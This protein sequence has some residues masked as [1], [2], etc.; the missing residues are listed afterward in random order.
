MEEITHR[1]GSRKHISDASKK[2]W[3][4][5]FRNRLRVKGTSGGTSGGT[6]AVFSPLVERASGA[7]GGSGCPFERPVSGGK[8][9]NT[10]AKRRDA[11][12]RSVKRGV[13]RGVK[14]G[15]MRGGGVMFPASFDN[16]PIRSFYGGNDFE[17][18]PNYLSVAGRQAGSFMSGGA[19]RNKRRSSSRQNRRR[20]RGG[21]A[22]SMAT[23]LFSGSMMGAQP[24]TRMYDENRTP[25]A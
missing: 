18:D 6:S 14:R 8:S 25:G 15:V 7:S 1:A 10:R 12:R 13:M 22:Y 11:K 23:G 16:V 5:S 3:F 2:H 20:S 4:N 9:R 24:I 19:R 17:N 21:S